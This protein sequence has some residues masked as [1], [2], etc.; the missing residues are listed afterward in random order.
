[1]SGRVRVTGYLV[2]DPEDAD[3]ASP[4]GLTEAAYDR[5]GEWSLD[6]LEDLR[7]VRES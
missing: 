6:D 7:V 2:P 1:M 3:P 5:L 4:T